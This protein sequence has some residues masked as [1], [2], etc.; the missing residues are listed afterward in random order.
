M[1]SKCKETLPLESATT[2]LVQQRWNGRK[3][4][5]GTRETFP[6]ARAHASLLTFP[7]LWGLCVLLHVKDFP[8]S[9]SDPETKLGILFTIL[10]L[11]KSF[12]SEMTGK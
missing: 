1:T 2:P 4:L 7:A 10:V 6:H 12:T 11:S 5:A 8:L 3:A 9:R